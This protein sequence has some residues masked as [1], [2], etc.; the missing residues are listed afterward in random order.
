MSSSVERMDQAAQH[1]SWRFHS[2]SFRRCAISAAKGGSAALAITRPSGVTTPQSLALTGKSLGSSGPSAP[3]SGSR[4]PSQLQS[5]RIRSIVIGYSSCRG[6]FHQ[7]CITPW[8]DA[9][10]P[11]CKTGAP[12][13]VRALTLRHKPARAWYRRLCSWRRSS[14]HRERRHTSCHRHKPQRQRRRARNGSVD[15]SRRC[16]RTDLRY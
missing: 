9:G 4:C 12:A 13:G 2:V 11:G 6:V 15:H 8:N 10:L 16:R 3:L 1:S 14:S 5:L 7:A